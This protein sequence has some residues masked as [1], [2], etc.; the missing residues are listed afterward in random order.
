MA[1]PP[2]A[3]VLLEEAMEEEG[4]GEGEEEEEEEQQQQEEEEGGTSQRIVGVVAPIT[5]IEGSNCRYA[6]LVSELTS[7][8]IAYGGKKRERGRGREGGRKD[9]NL[10]GRRG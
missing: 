1:R 9:G 2:L 4:E 3:M 8:V 5:P 10:N 6:P 7:R